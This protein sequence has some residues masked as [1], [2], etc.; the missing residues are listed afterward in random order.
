ME[1]WKPLKDFENYYEVSS[2]GRIKRL[3]SKILSTKALSS[4]YP[5]FSICINGTQITQRVHVSVAKTFLNDFYQE[6]FVVN[7]KDGNKLNNN[8]ENLEWISV[9]E[10][11][12]HSID[13]GLKG[14]KAIAILQFDTEGNFIKEFA[15]Q[16]EAENITGICR[17][18]INNCLKN[19]QKSAHNFVWKYKK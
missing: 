19:K 18:Q 8:V 12:K 6:G 7:H 1:L 17:K 9:Y 11:N 3:R 5:C 13:T 14:Y 15:S 4:G 16:K 10:N 2:Q